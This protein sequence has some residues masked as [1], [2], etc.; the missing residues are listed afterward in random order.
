VQIAIEP[1]TKGD[2]E[3][4]SNGLY[5]LAQEDPSFHYSR[6]EE[7]NQTVI[8]GMGELHLDIIVDRLRR[9]FKVD[10]NVGAPQVNYRE[11]I[12]APA[13][14][15]APPPL[16][17][18]ACPPLHRC[19]CMHARLSATAHAYRMHASTASACIPH[20]CLHCM[21]CTPAQHFLHLARVYCMRV[22][23]ACTACMYSQ[24]GLECTHQHGHASGW[25]C[26]CWCGCTAMQRDK[27]AACRH[28]VHTQETE[29]WQRAVC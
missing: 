9:E 17:M 29:W 14:M 18:H 1:K 15:P 24:G 25:D 13:G 19:A 11:A 2:L 10:C 26:A 8:E 3:K 12:T 4:M 16:R 23:H 28:Q 6:D 20:A 7:T 21:C 5:K 27:K 22:E